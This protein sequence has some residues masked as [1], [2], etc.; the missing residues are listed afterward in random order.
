MRTDFSSA[1]MISKED[2]QLISDFNE[3]SNIIIENIVKA[4][5]STKEKVTEEYIAIPFYNLLNGMEQEEP[6]QKTICDYE[7]SN[8]CI[9]IGK[10]VVCNLEKFVRSDNALQKDIEESMNL[11]KQALLECKNSTPETLLSNNP[12]WPVVEEQIRSAIEAHIVKTGPHQKIYVEYRPNSTREVEKVIIVFLLLV[13]IITTAVCICYCQYSY[14]D[15][16]KPKKN[17]NS[18]LEKV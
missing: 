1:V 15:N 5:D 16:E 3:F 12:Q 10:Y 2:N 13:A 11:A 18:M 9:H 17:D 14:N 4:I 8:S 7:K 6:R